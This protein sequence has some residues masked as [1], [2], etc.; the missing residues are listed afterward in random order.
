MFE[1]KDTFLLTNHKIKCALT[2]Q[3]ASQILLASGLSCLL[4]KAPRLEQLT[5]SSSTASVTLQ[6]KYHEYEPMM[7]LRNHGGKSI[8]QTAPKAREQALVGNFLNNAT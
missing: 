1:E 7:G 8:S 6:A 4:K 3:L 5:I 2:I